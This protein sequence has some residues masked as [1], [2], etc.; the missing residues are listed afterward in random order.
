MPVTEHGQFALQGFANVEIMQRYGFA[1]KL[2][3]VGQWRG[4]DGLMEYGVA[5]VLRQPGGGRRVGYAR[6]RREQ[7]EGAEGR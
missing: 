6:R 1:G 7:Q 3:G 4:G 2:E 5:A